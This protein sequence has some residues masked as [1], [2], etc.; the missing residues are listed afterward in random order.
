MRE[1]LEI[2]TKSHKITL[3]CLL[4]SAWGILLQ[5][6][7]HSEDVVFGTTVSGRSTDIKGIENIVG[8]FI[9]TVPLRIRTNSNGHEKITDFL[10]R[11]NKELREREEYESSSLVEI[12]G[13]GEVV[14]E[15]ELFD[16]IVV[17][18]NYPLDNS[19]FEG[20]GNLP[21][22]IKSY[23]MF[24]TTHYDLTVGI[25]LIEDI[26]VEFTYNVDLFDETIIKALSRHFMKI[27]AEMVD[28]PGKEFA[29]L[30]MLSEAEK[31]KILLEFND[32]ATDYP[33]EKN[34][35]GLF[36]QQVER[37]PD[38]IAAVAPLEMEYRTYR[39]YITYGEL[40]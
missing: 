35:H 2:F 19:L 14:F 18:E 33:K 11:V 39:T 1:K 16:T 15:G 6:Y 29:A 30:E 12:K 24:E 5:G 28:N 13:Y 25:T 21:L 27:V 8:M 34:L 17:I 4:Y 40:K 10:Y 7:N 36:A 38:N 32:T 26:E 23:S 3:A 31:N 20:N 22:S 9:N 37:T